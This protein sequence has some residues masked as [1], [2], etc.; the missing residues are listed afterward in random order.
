MEDLVL[1][2]VIDLDSAVVSN[3]NASTSPSTKPEPGAAAEAAAEAALLFGTPAD[4]NILL[5]ARDVLREHAVEIIAA[6]EVSARLKF[7]ASAAGHSDAEGY[8]LAGSTVAVLLARQA[9]PGSPEL[10][11]CCSYLATLQKLCGA[12]QMRMLK[13]DGEATVVGAAANAA[14]ALLA[15][16]AWLTKADLQQQQQLPSQA[17]SPQQQQQPAA[18][19]MES[20]AV[21]FLPSLVIVGQLF[22]SMVEL[23]AHRQPTVETQQQEVLSQPDEQQ[24][25][26][27][28]HQ[29]IAPATATVTRCRSI[30][31]PMSQCKSGQLETHALR[32]LVG[33]YVTKAHW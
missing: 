19:T 1:A 8:S 9:G 23:G 30:F 3:S 16:S 2:C 29:A 28:R 14:V 31:V 12:Q 22:L 32:T 24:Q 25:Q 11:Q 17:P 27:R 20:A 18:A 15:G 21:G 26:Q 10:Q 13:Q 7:R 6:L 5:Y 4:P 33:N